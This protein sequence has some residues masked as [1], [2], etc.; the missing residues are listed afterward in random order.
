[1]RPSAPRAL[2]ALTFVTGVV[3]ATSFL[4]LGG[5]FS[6]MMTGNVVFL[7]L[8]LSGG[9]DSSVVGPLFSI[10]AY[11]MASAVAALLARRTAG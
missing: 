5:V 4:A 9:G 3:D 6:A 8:G 10:A 1:M 2:L 11:V 7:G